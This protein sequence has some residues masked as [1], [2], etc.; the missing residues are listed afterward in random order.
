MKKKSSGVKPPAKKINPAEK[1]NKRVLHKSGGSRPAQGLKKKTNRSLPV[2]TR[3]DRKPFPIV[4]IGGSAGGME[5]FS[6][7]LENLPTDLGMAYVYIQHL[8]PNHE[9]FLPQILQRKTRMPVWQ[10]KN[11]MVLLKD[12]I[13]IIPASYSLTIANGKFKLETQVKAE[14]HYAVD[15][16]LTSLAPQYQQN[17]I[18]IILSGTGT[19]GTLGLMAIKAE[20]G[21]TFAQDNTADYTGMPT[22]AA[23]MGFVDFVMSPDK[24]AKE[25]ATLIRHPYSVSSPNDYLAEHKPDLR[26]IHL[27]MYSKHGVDFSYYKQTTIYRRIMRRMALNRINDVGT[28]LEMLKE[29]K[30]EVDALYQDLLITVTNFFRDEEMYRALTSKILPA[31]TKGRKIN[32][33]IRIWIPGCATGEEAVSFAVVLLEYLGEKAITTQIQIFATD[34]NE[35]AIERARAGI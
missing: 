27:L 17:A 8:S 14:G 7:L 19:D 4:G 5:A 20:G 26:K 2:K 1:N 18:G 3:D 15:K 11:N 25:L 35:K 24:I 13:Y 9:S 21:I 16:F 29:N 30:T 28:Y 34:L 22:H 32:D 12:H 33:P 23:G 31:L 10:V 6:R